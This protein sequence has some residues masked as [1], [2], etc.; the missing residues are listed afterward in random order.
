M[1]DR[2]ASKCFSL[3]GMQRNLLQCLTLARY[4]ICVSEVMQAIPS[5]PPY[6]TFPRW[7]TLAIM[8]NNSY[9]NKIQSR[10]GNKFI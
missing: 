4:L 9:T 10:R 2:Y 3:L 8:F 5:S 7:S 1:L 6:C